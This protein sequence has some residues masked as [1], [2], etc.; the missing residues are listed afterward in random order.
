[1]EGLG[2]GLG[3]AQWPADYLLGHVGQGIHVAESSVDTA[4]DF[5]WKQVQAHL[6]CPGG[7]H[8]LTFFSS[9]ETGFLLSLVWP[10]EEP[11]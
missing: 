7:I 1:M 2:R 4:D 10:C 8:Y 9:S 5:I 3:W 6:L 11:E